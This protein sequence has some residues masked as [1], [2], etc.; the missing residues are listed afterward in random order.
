MKQCPQCGLV[1]P[2]TNYYKNKTKKDGLQ[3]CCKECCNLNSKKFRETNPKYYWGDAGYFTQ[4]YEKTMEYTKE[5]HR[6]NKSSKIYKITTPDGIYIGS[7]KRKLNLRLNTHM[8]DYKNRFI[9]RGISVIP[10]LYQSFSKY[11][12]EEV[13]TFLRNVEL[14]EEFNGNLHETKGR[15]D[16]WIEYY[17]GMG[18]TMLNTYRAIGRNYHKK[19]KEILKNQK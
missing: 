11:S 17:R 1:K 19:E 14:I 8:G 13:R 10:L 5:I 2:E 12:I 16:F 6:A 15:E 18:Y 3:R 4:R 7:T 9:K